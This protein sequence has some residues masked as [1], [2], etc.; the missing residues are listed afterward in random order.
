MAE[1]NTPT[2][3]SE[4]KKCRVLIVDDN[5]DFAESLRDILQF[6]DFDVTIANDGRRAVSLAEQESF[7]I[8]LLDLVMPGMDGVDVLERIHGRRPETRFVIMTAYSN[9]ELADRARQ[10]PVAAVFRKPLPI[11]DVA[12]LLDRFR[13]TS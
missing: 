6:R 4:P 8:V 2:G 7:D 12:R 10:A 11:D 13:E 1:V 5:R 9:S 3:C